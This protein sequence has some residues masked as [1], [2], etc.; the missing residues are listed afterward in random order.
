M[1]YNNATLASACL[2]YSILATS[3]YAQ[4]KQQA[5][6]EEFY[7]SSPTIQKQQFSKQKQNSIQAQTEQGVITFSEF[8]KNT[9][10]TDQY[11][12]K[13]IVF[14]GDTP[15][16]TSDGSNPT[17]PVLSGY[18]RFNGAIEGHF[19]D[20]ADPSKTLTVNTFALDAGYFNNL[21][22]TAISW[23]DENGQLL[24]KQYDSI[25]GIERFEV[26]GDNIASFRIAIETEERAGFAIDNVWFNQTQSLFGFEF[27]TDKI[28]QQRGA[29]A[30]NTFSVYF[31]DLVAKEGGA[32]ADICSPQH[33]FI[34]QDGNQELTG[35]CSVEASKKAFKVDFT[36][37]SAPYVLKD[38]SMSIC[39]AS[40]C[41]VIE[42]L[43]NLSVYGTSFNVDQHGYAF[44]NGGWTDAMLSE[45]GIGCWVIGNC[46]LEQ[47]AV[48]GTLLNVA[49]GIT[50]ILPQHRRDEAYEIVGKYDGIDKSVRE[51]RN[52]G[53]VCYGLATSAASNFNNG[54][55][56]SAWGSS[57]VEG[58]TAQTITALYNDHWQ[59]RATQTPKPLPKDVNQYVATNKNDIV[60][61]IAQV[62][63]YFVTQG[64]YSGNGANSGAGSASFS[65]FSNVDNLGS[66]YAAHFANDNASPL[67][68]YFTKKGGHAIVATQLIEYN[69][70]T[71]LVTHDNNF[72]SEYSQL[73]FTGNA[74][75]TI[76][77]F[78]V[79]FKNSGTVQSHYG[80]YVAYNP[81]SGSGSMTKFAHITTDELELHGTAQ[82]AKNAF[83]FNASKQ[84][85]NNQS[86]KAD[87]NKAVVAMNSLSHTQV[88]VQ[89]ARVVSVIN[90]QTE[91][92][93]HLIPLAEQM[94]QDV[95]YVSRSIMSEKLYLSQTSEFEVEI[96]RYK[97][98]PNTRVFVK[99]TTENGT[100]EVINYE[101]ISSDSERFVIKVN[102][103]THI[104]TAIDNTVIEPTYVGEIT[105]AVQPISHLQA[106]ST[107]SDVQLSW[108][109]PNL[110]NI[111]E[112][113]T[114]RSTSG[115]P[116]SPNNGSEICDEVAN[117][118]NDTWAYS[119]TIY[120]YSVF[121]ITDDGQISNAESVMINTHQASIVGS[122][123]A[124]NLVVANVDLSLFTAEGI[125]VDL[126]NTTLSD[127]AGRFAF[128]G[129]PLGLYSLVVSGENIETQSVDIIVDSKQVTFDVVVESIP[130]IFINTENV[131]FV[132]E[133]LRVSWDV[134]GMTQSDELNVKLVHDNGQLN[135]ET[136][137][138]AQAGQI[139]WP[140][141]IAEQTVTLVVELAN[142]ETVNASA[143][144]VVIQPNRAPAVNK[145]IPDQ[146]A[147]SG[148]AF[149]FI[150]DAQTFTDADEGDELTYSATLASG[151]ELPSWL[152]F[153]SD[154][155]TFSATPSDTHIGTISIAVSVTDGEIS[156]PITDSF[157]INVVAA[158][159]IEK[160]DAESSGGGSFGW[161][162]LTLTVFVFT[163]RTFKP[164][165]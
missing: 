18:P 95:S 27:E 105:V 46:S 140:V 59:N 112:V 132:G 45:G 19:V 6:S 125:Q 14:A 144:V 56:T 68:F 40:Q 117:E 72:P 123:S 63:Y 93:A 35:T 62:A 61:G 39:L 114:V 131:A 88:V 25:Y 122:I 120:Y 98:F 41:E 108:T 42:D 160:G 130:S 109:L 151:A 64:A 134:A 82:E 106:S 10:I 139:I 7:S 22:S 104:E 155:R 89:G 36:L 157:S 34:V 164:L 44:K 58:S 69:N 137:L 78:V 111:A 8:A 110:P 150:F 156:E 96:E 11:A 100:V 87:S 26:R 47:L 84:N 138:A 128:N 163:R 136:K 28:Y 60:Q 86:V 4:T 149:S 142:D 52:F 77:H 55:Q 103:D 57:I 159:I 107:G 119:D 116:E 146:Q 113:I 29:K 143:Q 92:P 124:D 24:G 31:R 21:S 9:K 85:V 2:A 15:F 161:F 1:K 158:P 16:I 50:P 121:V 118:C 133:N 48:H 101:E 32:L 38:A 162:T 65:R 83:N 33:S 43:N 17:S 73:E 97:Q 94:A 54:A 99:H 126:I 79:D 23:Y 74:L 37:N 13:G 76:P 145:K 75:S 53:G 3:A 148:R 67:V 51:D 147:Q 71:V 20:P 153:D 5:N 70:T 115:F 165:K 129:L 127:L 102:S 80:D 30:S 90:K 66:Y 12:D 141:D 154:T 49:D 91:E 81:Y 135:L 152:S